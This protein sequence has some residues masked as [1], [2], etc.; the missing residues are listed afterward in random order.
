M[1]N[2][3]RVAADLKTA[4]HG[5]GGVAVTG[6]IPRTI[7]RSLG[8][9]RLAAAALVA[10]C[11][12]RALVVCLIIGMLPGEGKQLNRRPVVPGRLTPGC[13][14]EKARSRQAAGQ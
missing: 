13:F 2:G 1:I 14:H 4:I 12:P 9:W 6:E 10:A 3:S 5:Q 8:R 7:G 11:L